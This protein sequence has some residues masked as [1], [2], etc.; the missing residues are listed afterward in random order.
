MSNFIRSYWKPLL[1]FA[2]VGLVGGFFV[3]IYQLDSYPA[4]IQQQLFEQGA[5]EDRKS[6]V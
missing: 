6:V 2:V 3:G 4:E 1:F 5:T